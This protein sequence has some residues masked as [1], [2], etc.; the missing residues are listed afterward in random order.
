MDERTRGIMARRIYWTALARGVRLHWSMV[1]AM[2]E[3]MSG[4]VDS[5]SE[6]RVRQDGE[7]PGS[8]HAAH[9]RWEF[10]KRP[11]GR[12]DAQAEW[13]DIEHARARARS[14]PELR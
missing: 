11:D 4:I 14:H 6:M 1:D 10:T 12:A 13:A 9:A 8:V 7:I 5:S 3:A 2:V